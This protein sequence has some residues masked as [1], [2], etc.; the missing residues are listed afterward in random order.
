MSPTSRERVLAA[1]DHR[2]PDRV[3]VDL[4]ATPS[5]GISA[6][7][8]GRLKRHL[9]M[10]GGHTRVYDVVQQLAQPEDAILDRFRIDA[11]DVGRAFDGEDAD[12]YEIELPG[13]A[14]GRY[15]AGFRPERQPDGGWIARSADGTP[16]ARMPAAGTFFDQTFYPWLAGYPADLAGLPAAMGKV[17]WAAFASSPWNHAGEAG[18]WTE[19]RRRALALRAATDRAIVIGVGCNLFEW[20]TFLRRLD[21]FV[22]DLIERPREVERFLDALLGIHLATLE[23][24]CAA[25]GDVADIVK[26]GD[27]LGTDTG[28]F[29]SP[30]LYRRLFRPR[31]AR[32]CELVRAR[33]TMRTYLHSCGSIYA[34][35]PDLIEAGF[36]VINPVQ[37]SAR[38][39]DPARLKREFG[40][41]VTFWGGGCDTREVLNRASPARVREHVLERLEILAPGGGFVFNTIHNILPDVPPANIV[42]M[43]E[44]IEEF[45]GR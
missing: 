34:L 2:E 7:A 28:P 45:Q 40:R 15:P 14:P 16:I 30:A 20:G 8:Y 12:W 38:D 44:A 4:G 35:L 13:G 23:R 22:C 43:Y 31:H 25:V 33:S 18:F 9:G 37:T 32:L 3:P 10:R 36:E 39:M 41:D 26:F 27:D 19:L 29:L 17:L 11:V 1:L 21:N 6:L 42:A 5:T 24:V